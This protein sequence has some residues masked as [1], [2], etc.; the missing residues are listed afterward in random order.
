MN[1]EDSRFKEH[2]IHKVTTTFDA[3]LACSLSSFYTPNH[4]EIPPM[5]LNSAID[6]KPLCQ[7]IIVV[8]HWKALAPVTVGGTSK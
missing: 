3:D 4:T 7:I 2:S 6:R 5:D 8:S 1:H